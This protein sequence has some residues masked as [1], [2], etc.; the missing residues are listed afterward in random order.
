MRIYLLRHG[1]AQQRPPSGADSA[2]RELVDKGRKQ[3]EEVVK[4]LTRMGISFDRALSSPYARARQTAEAVLGGLEVSAALQL[5][6]RLKPAGIAARAISSSVGEGSAERVLAVG[7]EPL[8]SE[9]AATLISAPPESVTLR[10][11]GLVELQLTSIRPRRA[12]ILGLIRPAH[13][14]G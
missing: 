7:H 11:G 6:E 12:M 1:T 13:L 4:L 2:D 9:I 8:L 10:K 5:D 3:C 14:R